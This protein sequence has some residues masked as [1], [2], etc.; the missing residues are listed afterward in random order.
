MRIDDRMA[1]NAVINAVASAF[2][3][4]PSLITNPTHQYDIARPRHVVAWLLYRRAGWSYPRIGKALGGRHHTTIM[5][6]VRV[7]DRRKDSPEAADF[8]ARMEVNSSD[9]SDWLVDAARRTSS[10]CLAEDI[11]RRA[12]GGR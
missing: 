1:A 11:V 6:S 4:S 8:L 3:V 2:G 7:V 9:G 5:H 10:D 12:R